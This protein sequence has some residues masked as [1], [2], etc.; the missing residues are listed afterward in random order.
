[1]ISLTKLNNKLI[2]PDH[3]A[4]LQEPNGLLAYGGD[5]SIQRLMLAYSHGIFPWYGKDDPIMWWSPDPRGILPLSNFYCSSKLAKLVRQQR[6]QVS[7]NKAF[8]QVI[9][10]CASIARH[11]VGAGTWITPQ[12]IKAYKNLHRAGHAHSIEVWD[13]NQLV[14]GLYGVVSGRLFCGESM[15]HRVTDCSKLAMYYLVE[16]LRS[17][18]SPFIDCQMQNPHLSSLGCIELPRQDFLRELSR[19]NGQSFSPA[20]WQTRWLSHT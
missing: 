6:Y 16:L 3:A 14:G 9:D 13:D 19:L 15:F 11:G 8:V 18:N 10:A 20:C 1:M 17:E 2:F 7:V 5:L 12:M 4:A